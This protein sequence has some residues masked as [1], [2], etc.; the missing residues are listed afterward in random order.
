[1][2]SRTLMA[3]S[4]AASPYLRPACKNQELSAVAAAGSVWVGCEAVVGDETAGVVLLPQEVRASAKKTRRQSSWNEG[5][6]RFGEGD[7]D[8]D[9]VPDLAI[10]CKKPNRFLKLSSIPVS[11]NTQFRSIRQIS[12]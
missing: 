8:D 3:I 2:T 10:L 12:G 6:M 5:L 9:N 1:M 11:E 4:L 7:S